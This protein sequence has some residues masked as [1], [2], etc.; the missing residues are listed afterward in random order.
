MVVALPCT[1]TGPSRQPPPPLTRRLTGG[2]GGLWGFRGA[3][4]DPPSCPALAPQGPPLLEAWSHPRD[5]GH[6]CAEGGSGHCPLPA[7]S[8][9]YRG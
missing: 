5:R 9:S 1:L 6:G 4:E 2:G 3:G 8:L 7:L